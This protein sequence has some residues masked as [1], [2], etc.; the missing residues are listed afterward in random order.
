MK[1]IFT[2]KIYILLLLLG[3]VVLLSVIASVAPKKGSNTNIF[4]N[5]FAQ[6]N[7]NTN[8]SKVLNQ[9]E[10]PVLKFFLE[11]NSKLKTQME[12]VNQIDQDVPY[13]NISWKVN[14]K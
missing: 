13:P 5:P 1:K 10:D 11:Q 3:L 14:F 12:L 4:L 6:N 8:D 7:K 2:N 9:I